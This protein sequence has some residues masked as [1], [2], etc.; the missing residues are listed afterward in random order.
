MTIVQFNSRPSIARLAC[1]SCGAQTDAACNCGVAYKPV[2]IAKTYVKENPSASVRKIAQDTG[3]SRAT[4]H[5]AKS[6]V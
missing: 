6:G 2:E 1:T 3:V 4:A 5:R